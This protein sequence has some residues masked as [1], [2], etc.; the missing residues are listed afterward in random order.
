[1]DEVVLLNFGKRTITVSGDRALTPNASLGFEAPEAE[2]LLTLYPDEV[3]TVD[4]E[5]KSVTV[6]EVAVAEVAEDIT[7]APEAEK[8]TA[9]KNK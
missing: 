9:R 4:A 5:V 8:K 3:K 2:K 1:M 6:E 7:E